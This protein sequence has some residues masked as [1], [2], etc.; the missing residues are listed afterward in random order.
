M[1]YHAGNHSVL[2][3]PTTGQSDTAAPS[4]DQPESATD[5]ASKGYD[6]TNAETGVSNESTESPRYPTRQRRPPSRFK[7]YVNSRGMH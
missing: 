3:P 2:Q 6:I 5:T 7:D 4:N 1:E